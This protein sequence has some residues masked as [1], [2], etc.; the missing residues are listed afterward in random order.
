MKINT[1]SASTNTLEGLTEEALKNWQRDLNKAL[2]CEHDFRTIHVVCKN[3]SLGGSWDS[4]VIRYCV[5]CCVKCEIQ[6]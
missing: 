3:K 2:F 6:D 4:H 1:D 5:K